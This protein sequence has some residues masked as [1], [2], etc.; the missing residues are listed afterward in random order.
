MAVSRRRSLGIRFARPAG[1]SAITTAV[2][3]K[4]AAGDGAGGTEATKTCQV[5]DCPPFEEVDVDIIF[6]C[7][8]FGNLGA[9]TFPER[10]T[11]WN[12]LTLAAHARTPRTRRSTGVAAA[13][14]ARRSSKQRSGCGGRREGC[15]VCV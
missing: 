8:Q 2:G 10:V 7:L 13:D 3:I 15:A 11:Q 14:G 9:R 4:T 6:H 1:L 5:V 12:N